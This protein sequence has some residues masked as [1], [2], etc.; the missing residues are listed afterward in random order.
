MVNVTINILQVKVHKYS[1]DYQII[2]GNVNNN[3]N[4]K[5]FPSHIH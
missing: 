5:T 2:K 1:C 4:N 3:N